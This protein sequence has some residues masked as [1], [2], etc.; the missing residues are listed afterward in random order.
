MT[1]ELHVYDHCDGMIAILF[2]NPDGSVEAY[3]INGSASMGQFG[4]VAEAAAAFVDYSQSPAPCRWGTT[5]S[6]AEPAKTCE[7]QA[8]QASEGEPG[9]ARESGRVS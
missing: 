6:P 1:K 3:D 5:A 4:S 9:R 2:V 7:H 8:E